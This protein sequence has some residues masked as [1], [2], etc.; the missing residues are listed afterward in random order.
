[1]LQSHIEPAPLT[2][3]FPLFSVPSRRPRARL[4]SDFGRIS[5][6]VIAA[7]MLIAVCAERVHEVAQT[8]LHGMASAAQ[9][10]F[11]TPHSSP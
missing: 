1:M 8:R 5:L 6:L 9:P 2:A 11:H 10:P 7:F 3:F 4:L